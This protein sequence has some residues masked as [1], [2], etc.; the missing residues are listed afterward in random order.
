[1]GGNIFCDASSRKIIV[2]HQVS[3][4]YEDT[5]MYTEKFE[6]KSM[7]AGVPVE[8]YSIYNGIYTS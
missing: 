5:N 3:F 8:S 4:T 2:D 1:M 7:V 6:R